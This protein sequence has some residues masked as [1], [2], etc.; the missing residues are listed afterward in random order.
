MVMFK[1]IAFDL[2]VIRHCRVHC[3]SVED[4]TLAKHLTI[5]QA[6][7]SCFGEFLADLSL[8]DSKCI[9]SVAVRDFR[10]TE[11]RLII[12]EPRVK[13]T[14]DKAFYNNLN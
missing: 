5:W 14:A 4:L 10:T 9:M 7:S 6:H 1:I 3:T 11:H 8:D 12:R 13:K 2:L